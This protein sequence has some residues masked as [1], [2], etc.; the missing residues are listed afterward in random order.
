MCNC[1]KAYR[2]EAECK[3]I[4]LNVHIQIGAFCFFVTVAQPHRRCE[5]LPILRLGLFCL[6]WCRNARSKCRDIQCTLRLLF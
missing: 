6:W 2:E 5:S 3:Y 1:I 4:S